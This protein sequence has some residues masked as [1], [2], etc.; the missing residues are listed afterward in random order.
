MATAAHPVIRYIRRL[1]ATP[2]AGPGDGEL[3]GRFARHGDQAA[4]EALVRRHGPTVLGACRRVL[5]DAH[6]ADDAFQ[7]TFLVLAKKAGALERPAALGPWLYGV[8]VRTALKARAGAAR[9]R[10]QERQAAVAEAV[11]ADDGPVWRE[12]RPLLDEEVA[13]LPDKYRVPF[14]LHHLEG[15]TVDDVAGRLGC[16]RGTV[17]ARL[18]RA[19]ERLRGRLV[20]RGVALSAAALAA[21]LAEVAAAAPV[22]V[23]LVARAAQA[24]AAGAVPAGA[25]ALANGVLR[26]MVMAKLKVAAVALAVGL[27]G[28]AGG[29]AAWQAR[30]AG[31]AAAQQEGAAK[32]AV[33]ADADRLLFLAGSLHFLVEEDYRAAERAFSLLLKKYPDSRFAPKAA[34][35]AVLAKQFT[36][37][38]GDARKATEGRHAI[39]AALAAERK[40]VATQQAEKDFAM[41]EFYRRSGHAGAACFYYDMVRRRYP[42]TP[43]TEKALARLRELQAKAEAPKPAAEK[44]ARVGQIIIIGNTKTP[45]EAI[46]KQVPLYP[47]QV[48][49][50]PDL[51]AAEKNLERTG[52]F[53]VDPG[54]G[55]RPTVTV[56]EVPDSE[57]KDIIITVQEGKTGGLMFGQGTDGGSVLL[58][59][60]K[61][62]ERN[63]DVRPVPAGT[64]PKK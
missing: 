45:T 49:S 4:F 53:V 44:P 29:V 37:R 2:A 26:G 55:V 43:F 57:F 14:V 34:E 59:G 3:L 56:R 63:L 58:G 23:A 61:V 35:L 5:R 46:L 52:R 62:N 54:K 22:P 10:E 6:A 7:A 12:L 64:A 11:A 18:A 41:A 47:G 48:L 9:R 17:A 60:L 39:E 50:Y 36:T 16:P 13:R 25:A 40:D 31:P 28:T 8:A 20:R 15:R 42:G 38:G 30:A 33:E 32:S 21:A 19:R 1:S 51:K 27:A 24:V